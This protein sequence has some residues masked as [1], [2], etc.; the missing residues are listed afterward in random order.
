MPGF[1]TT[2]SF[3]LTEFNGAGI[4][5]VRVWRFTMSHS[6]QNMCVLYIVDSIGGS[7]GRALSR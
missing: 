4:A 5:D 7:K 1:D 6:S 3:E 2:N